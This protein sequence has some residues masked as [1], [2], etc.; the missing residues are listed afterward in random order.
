MTRDYYLR[1]P[2]GKFKTMTFS[3]DDDVEQ[4]ER[5][6]EIFK[7]NNLRAT[8]NLNG[9]Q[10]APEGTTY[11]KGETHRHITKEKAIEIF[12]NDFC[13]V[14]CHTYTHPS[15]AR[16]NDFAIIN[17]LVYDR[18]TLEDMFGKTVTGMAYPMGS[19]DNRVIELCK[20]AGIKYSRTV[21]F[22]NGGFNLPNNW[23]AFNPTCHHNNSNLNE[24]ADKFLSVEKSREPMMFCLWGHAYEFEDRDNWNVI[25][26]FAEKISNKND[27][28]YATV[29]EIYRVW[30]NF[31]RLE[32][33]A[34]G[35]SVFNPTCDE[36]WFA[37]ADNNIYFVKSG[38]TIQLGEPSK[39]WLRI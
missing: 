7:K 19:Y 23:L 11:P 33:S 12:S 26:D 31:T 34:D 3:Y 4:N 30:L 9:G 20:A 1:F 2:D 18:R 8:F 29:G 27:I 5:L 32:F 35:M 6:I 36:V 17:E 38:D 22:G 13:E 24:I 37:D 15:L 10:F 21:N 28:W 14:A 25:E 16:C 39:S